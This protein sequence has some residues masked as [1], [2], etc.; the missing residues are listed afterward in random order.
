MLYAPAGRPILLM[1]DGH[2]SHYDP[3]FIRSAAEKGVI[4][5]MLP[6]NTTHIAQPLDNTPFKCLK[7]CWDDECNTYM[8]ENPGK[9]VTIYSSQSFLQQHGFHATGVF[10]VNH[11]AIEI[12]GVKQRSKATPLAAVAKKNG[13]NYLP[14]FSPAARKPRVRSSMSLEFTDEEMDFFQR[15]YKEEYDIP[16]DLRYEA[17]LEMYHPNLSINRASL[18]FT[19]KEINLKGDTRRDMI[20]LVTRGMKRAANVLY[21]DVSVSRDLLPNPITRRMLK[22]QMLRHMRWMGINLLKKSKTWPHT[23]GSSYSWR[24]KKPRDKRRQNS[25]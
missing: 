16:G 22:R 9:V 8:S 24:S 11:D 15:R 7:G 3:H 19:D 5:F 23:E 1:L 14:L 4:V 2:S 18:Q 21:P 17:W 25:Y 10:P 6:P 13:I 20:F 12:P